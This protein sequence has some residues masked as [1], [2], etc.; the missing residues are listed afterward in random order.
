MA[1]WLKRRRQ[2]LSGWSG[3]GARQSASARMSAPARAIQRADRPGELGAVGIFEP[4][5]ELARRPVLEAGDG[6]GAGEDRRV[7]HRLR[8]QQPLAEILLE[9]RAETLAVGPLDEPHRAPAARAERAMRLGRGAAGEAGRRIERV[10]RGLRQ[11]SGEVERPPAPVVVGV[12]GCGESEFRIH[13]ARL[14]RDRAFA[15][16][17]RSSHKDA[18]C[19]RRPPPQ[20]FDRALVRRRLDRAWARAGAGSGAD[21]LLRRAAEELADRL[22]LV[23]RRFALAA[24]LG[25]PGP[26]AAAAVAASGQ[27]DR[28]VRLAPTLAEPRRGRFSGAVGDVER[29]PLADGR[30]D[31]AVS[32]LALQTVNDLPGALIQM[33]RALAPDG[34][35]VVALLGGD[36]LT[37]LRQSLTLAESEVLGGA[38]PRV[39]PFVDLRALGSLAQRAGLAL[40]VVDL[41]R[42]PVRYS[43]IVALMRDLRAFG[44]ANA[45]ADRSRKPL[46]REVLGARRGGLRGG[47]RRPGR[48][49]ARD[50][51]HRLAQRLGA[52][53]SQPK[54]LKPGSATVRLADALKAATLT[55]PALVLGFAGLRRRTDLTAARRRIKISDG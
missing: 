34:L 45:L 2:S 24:D 50:L 41:D 1:A 54:P 16:E 22:S 4:V 49:A 18:R 11:P 25:T 35:L 31:L 19:P 13:A 3:T 32:L 55:G 15:R 12:L 28:V 14:A 27:A 29:L 17:D 42:V 36:T 51:R 21:F 44:A 47:V 6:A 26:H 52:D 5:D 10:D 33:R 7:G 37:E 39:A 43:D 38:A 53:E 30:F 40:P 20:I 48:T 9:R 46:R 8:R 23:K